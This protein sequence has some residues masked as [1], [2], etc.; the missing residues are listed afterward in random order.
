MVKRTVNLTLLIATAVVGAAAGGAVYGLHK[1]QVSRTAKGL[2]VLAEAQ[3]K[4]SQWQK[5][6][7]YLDR[8]LRL[9]PDDAP[10]AGRLALTF[11]KGA[12]FDH[13]KQRAVSLHYT[14]LAKEDSG[15]VAKLRGGLADL[16]LDLERFG[17]AETESRK[18]LEANA[19]DPQGTRVLSLA[20]ASQW[21]DGSLA[22]AD[23][24][25]LAILG[26]LEKARQT[27][28]S[29]SR[30]A[31]ALAS[32][33]RD[34]AEISAAELPQLSLLDRQ[35]R[36]NDVMDQLVAA[37]PRE[38]KIHLSRYFY[39]T[40]YALPEAER[41]L[42]DAVRLAPGETEV[43]LAAGM[44]ALDAGNRAKADPAQAAK[45]TQHFARAQGF[46]EK[47]IAKP[48]EDRLPA[49]YLNLG[50]V[51]LAQTVVT[52]IAARD[53][54]R[55]VWRDGLKLYRMPTVQIALQSK[56]AESY[57]EENRPEEAGESL[58][59]I[60]K[61]VGRLG[62]SVS[63][64]TRI[65]LEREWEL[66]KAR[67]HI[68]R[69]ESADAIE[70]LRRVALRQPQG[71]PR[72]EMTLQATFLLGSVQ[73][74]LGEW[75]DAAIA[76]D[77]VNR[78]A[79]N[80]AAARLAAARAY[81]L[82]GRPQLAVERAEQAVASAKS[83]DAW[84]VLASAEFQSQVTRPADERNWQRLEEVLF[85]LEQVK[86]ELGKQSPWRIDFLRVDYLMAKAEGAADPAAAKAEAASVLKSAEAAYGTDKA[87]WLQV[88][89][90]YQGLGLSEEAQRC[91]AEL[92][93][94]EGTAVEAAIAESRLAVSRED[95]DGAKKILEAAAQSASEQQR[96]VLRSELLRVA[97]AAKDLGTAR[98]ILAD[99][100][101]RQPADL[102]V[103]RRA[104]ELELDQRD[105]TAVDRWVKAAAQAG[106]GNAGKLL[107]TYLQAWRIYLSSTNN[108]DTALAQ[109]LT[110]LQQVTLVR[111]GWAQAIA[112]Q[113]LLELRLGKA[114][115]AATNLERAI[116]LGERRLF[117][118]EQLVALLESQ[119]RWADAERYLAR[120][121]GELPRSQGLAEAAANFELYRDQ[122]QDAV[123]I[124]RESLAQRPSDPRAHWW[125]GRILVVTSAFAEAE[126]SLEKSIELDPSSA[127]AW[128]A[129]VGLHVRTKERVKAEQ[130]LA[131]LE[132]N[133]KV[134]ELQKR[135]LLAQG[136]DSL[137][138]T[139][140]ARKQ[141]GNLA[142]SS[143][144]DLNVQ[145]RIAQFYL[146]SDPVEAERMLRDLL[147]Q[148]PDSAS[149]RRLLALA[150]ASRGSAG[151]EEAQQ[152]L[153][154]TAPGGTVDAE[155]QRIRALLLVQQG[156]VAN[157][158][159]AVQIVETLVLDKASPAP[160][161][162]QL[163][164]Q[165][166]ERQVAVMDDPTQTAEKLLAAQQQWQAAAEEPGAPPASY[167]AVIQFLVRHGQ[168]AETL[169]WL[170]RLEAA[171]EKLPKQTADLVGLVVQM[172]ILAGVTDRSEKWLA[173]SEMAKDDGLRK[174]ALAVQVAA[175]NDPMADVEPMIEPRAI[176]LVAATT[177]PADKIAILTGVGDLYTSLKKYGPAE[178]WYRQLVAI[179][180]EQYPLLVGA[181]AR[182]GRLSDAIAV[183][184]EAKQTD[185]TT[186]PAMVLTAA[187]TE[188]QP[189]EQDFKQAAPVLR[190]TIDKFPKD[191][192]LLYAA[193]LVALLERKYDEATVLYRQILAANP[194]HIAALNNLAMLL[195]EEPSKRTE[196]VSLI[197]RAIEIVGKDPGLLDTKGAILAYSSKPAEALPLLV[198]S[199]RGTSADPRH[200]LHLAIVYRDLGRTDEGK[201]Q[202]KIALDRQLDKQLLMPTDQRLLAELQ[203]QWNR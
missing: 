117:V 26:S 110:D 25:K 183:C 47:L 24:K 39:R 89:L 198:S 152:L 149:V 92:R 79:P 6:A 147:V 164:A 82:T 150:V 52:D 3:E 34:S 169:P 173:A 200:H 193:S 156:G 136:Y 102:S 107:A 80:L 199:I 71:D 51:R 11:A 101:R 98:S 10:A 61:L 185:S 195:A 97:M 162:R 103:I 106:N 2:L 49:A 202:L 100:H 125:L 91:L 21:A 168:K 93:K 73:F 64:Q 137:G 172:Q 145:L 59:E 124:A 155:D 170:D 30:V 126:Q 148:H 38:G 13:E 74:T 161:D 142:G 160:S 99:E 7:N 68:Q 28:P 55:N 139:D 196:A 48:E 1:W 177:N 27:N 43:L 56:I 197:D 157:L 18:L 8:Y 69:N 53:V 83:V 5:A 58:E 119:Q 190:V 14:A 114:D 181:L 20:L 57:L 134:P 182:Q 144:A 4:E 122:P 192:G 154:Q 65:A 33:L 166:Y 203:A 105:F 130:V 88:C 178:R 111:P 146:K 143:A 165:L 186:R 129:L 86:S 141:F 9:K 140:D 16:L 112:V 175:A 113:G 76:F 36:A 60:K 12:Q 87:F 45:A 127:S 135:L 62:T 17:E 167:A 174:L 138:K 32:L 153:T 44:H 15:D 184:E 123:K 159:R 31:L 163:L 54:A 67:W 42:D 75:V 50:D 40:K 85:A 176:E 128:S 194:Q 121:A 179:A 108:T 22:R 90:A 171:V 187:L 78:L 19:N 115:E 77:E 201:E 63:R 120:L 95:H 188:S 151:L 189:T 66:R 116:N 133:D 132:Q 84:L 35:Q 29:D 81:L 180:P 109:A 41:D 46:F 23:L 191:V 94:F 118:Y 70:L 131:R 72:I 158:T 37:N 96:A 104:A